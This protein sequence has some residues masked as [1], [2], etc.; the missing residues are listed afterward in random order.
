[1]FMSES[2]QFSRILELVKKQ[3]ASTSKNME[4]L[5]DKRGEKYDAYLERELDS[6]A[7]VYTDWNLLELFLNDLNTQIHLLTR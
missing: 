2:I 7:E 4:D 5:I 1:M 6:V 3:R